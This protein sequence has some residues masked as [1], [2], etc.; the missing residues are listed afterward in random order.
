MT[1][2]T[3]FPKS[4]TRANFHFAKVIQTKKKLNAYLDCFILEACT[5][6]P[7]SQQKSSGM[8]CGNY[9]VLPDAQDRYA[10]R[11]KPYIIFFEKFGNLFDD[12]LPKNKAKV[13]NLKSVTI[14]AINDV[15]ESCGV[16]VLGDNPEN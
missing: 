9:G 16:S 3:K 1:R 7:N 4:K 13:T 8:P 2:C 15:L 5:T 6:T 12:S 10:S 14:S 11:V